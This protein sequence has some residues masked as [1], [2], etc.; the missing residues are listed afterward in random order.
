MALRLLIG[1]H[2]EFLSLQGAAQ[3][4]L[5]LHLFHCHIVIN[6]MLQLNYIDLEYRTLASLICSMNHPTLRP[7]FLY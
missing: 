3:A 5:S 7:E 1:F 4:R 6:H 2:L